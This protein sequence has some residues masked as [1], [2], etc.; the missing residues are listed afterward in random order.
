M[1]RFIT[2]FALVAVLLSCS[3]EEGQE[4][5]EPVLTFDS[6]T[7]TTV[8]ELVEEIV[9]KF[10]YNDGDG[11]LGENDASVKNLFITDSRNQVVNSFR[12]KQLSPDNSTIAIEGSLNVTISP[13][14]ITD[15]STSEKGTFSLY[16][17]DRAGNKSNV[18]TSSE[19]TINE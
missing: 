2:Y 12:V 14:V 5:V 10:S 16:M 7:P 13:L 19:F 4:N 8:N 11:N 18:I 9:L 1:R 3:K 6:M 15:G 17:T